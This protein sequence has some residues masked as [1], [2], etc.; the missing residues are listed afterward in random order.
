MVELLETGN[1]D[2][3]LRFATKADTA[4][5]FEFIQSLAEF[6]KLSHE[7]SADEETL[8]ESL[9]GDRK[10][11]EVIIAEYRGSPAGFALF[12]IIIRHLSG[13]P[14]STWKTYS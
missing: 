6:E 8:R 10:Y 2:L 7:V 5:V 4:L 12:F 11:A 13:S 1:P 14:A 3:R 9:F